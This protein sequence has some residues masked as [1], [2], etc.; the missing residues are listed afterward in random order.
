MYVMQMIQH[1]EM[2][3]ILHIRCVILLKCYVQIGGLIWFGL[4]KE[5]IPHI[6]D[7]ECDHM[8]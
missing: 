6:E 8:L 3:V 1:M 2:Y 5:L 7:S 4:K